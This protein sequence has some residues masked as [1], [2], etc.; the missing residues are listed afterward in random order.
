MR[1]L[2]CLV[3]PGN[4]NCAPVTKTPLLASLPFPMKSCFR[5]LLTLL[6]LAS[7]IA[8]S[9][10][11]SIGPEVK[12]KV[13]EAEPFTFD[14]LLRFK[15]VIVRKFEPD[16]LRIR[17][18]QGVCKVT[19]EEL[20]EDVRQKY[21]MTLEGAQAYRE[22]VRAIS[23]KHAQ[24]NLYQEAL[25]SSKLWVSGEILQVLP[26]GILL[27][28]ASAETT[29]KVA[30]KVPYK[31]EIDGP[32]GLHPDRPRRFRTEYKT[33]WIPESVNL[34]SLVFVR[35][36]SHS[37][38][39]GQAYKADIYP[40]G[41]YSYVSVGGGIRVVASYETDL[42]SLIQDKL[43]REMDL[44]ESKPA[45]DETLTIV[46]AHY[47]TSKVWVDVTERANQLIANNRLEVHS[48]CP[49]SKTAT[50]ISPTDPLPYKK[51][52]TTITYRIGSGEVKT[53][54]VPEGEKI[55]VPP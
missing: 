44:P 54:W 55:I 8:V 10:A 13:E 34:G 7:L 48:A 47:G 16:G 5:L 14:E 4:R 17:H 50:W 6:S 23:L 52:H 30:K 31:V 32:T 24:F 19:F 51:K 20:P 9:S 21:G 42:V 27:R 38:S 22:K 3:E 12:Q 37:L 11:Q 26:D 49:A 15:K 28:F 36:E 45:E 25:K 33:E 46:K 29:K 53:L 2:L 39:E 43:L 18:E 35:C 1:A 41:S 40:N